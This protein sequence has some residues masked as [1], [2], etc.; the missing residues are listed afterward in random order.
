MRVK[1]SLIRQKKQ[2][3]RVIEKINGVPLEM[4]VIPPGSFL[5]GAPQ[6]E[7]DSFDS[8]RPQHAVQVD[9]FYLGRYP[10]TQAQWEAVASLPQ[11]G[12]ELKTNPSRFKG[13]KR[14]VERVSWYDAVEFCARLSN[15]L[16]KNYRLP[17]EAEWE[18]A[19]R[20]GTLTPFHFGETISTDVANYD[21]TREKYG[22]YGLGNKGEYRGE[23]T[24]VDHFQI[25]NNFGLADMHG[26]VLEWCADSW[27]S[28]Y[29]GAPNNS[30][31]WD[32]NSN[33]QNDYLNNIDKLLKLNS[34]RVVRS[35]SWLNNPRNCRSASR[36]YDHPGNDFNGS[37]GLRVAYVARAFS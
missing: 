3:S 17:S 13:P 18:Y 27:R 7:L 21:G 16:E 33:Y 28:D 29:Q 22:A 31:V 5:M 8:E 1:T 10:V 26:N 14:P 30:R 24:D 6:G 37:I 35:G 34:T 23:T 2:F 32:D 20:A 12:K 19:C 11:Q 4:I 36:N 9:S 15:H 25:A